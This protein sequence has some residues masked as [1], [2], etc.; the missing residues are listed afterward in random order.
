MISPNRWAALDSGF[1]SDSTSEALSQ[2]R[3]AAYGQRMVIFL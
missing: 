1:S 2:K 3:P